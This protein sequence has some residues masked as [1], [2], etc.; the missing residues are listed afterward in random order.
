VNIDCSGRVYK[1]FSYIYFLFRIPES[2]EY[3]SSDDDEEVSVRP[4]AKIRKRKFFFSSCCSF[5]C[6]LSNIRYGQ[7][8]VPISFF[9]KRMGS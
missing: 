5:L 9:L 3:S 7:I 4:R 6:C 8:S 1:T 2:K